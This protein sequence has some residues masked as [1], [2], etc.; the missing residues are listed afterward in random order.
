MPE[1]RD[2]PV[3]KFGSTRTALAEGIQ[4]LIVGT[5]RGFLKIAVGE[6]MAGEHKTVRNAPGS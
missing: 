6:T 3:T 2:S 1:L 5:K 4:A